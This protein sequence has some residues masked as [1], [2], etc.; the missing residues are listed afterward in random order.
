METKTYKVVGP[1]HVDGHAPGTKFEAAYGEDHEAYLVNAG[2]IQVV[3]AKQEKKE[4]K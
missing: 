1:R 3:Q 2:H 4:A